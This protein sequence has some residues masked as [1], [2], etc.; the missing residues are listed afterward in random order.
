MSLSSAVLSVYDKAKDTMKTDPD[1]ALEIAN[2]ISFEDYKD[3]VSFYSK[4]KEKASKAIPIYNQDL[5]ENA[6]FNA[7]LDC[8]SQKKTSKNNLGVV[9]TTS[10]YGVLNFSVHRIGFNKKKQ[11]SQFTVKIWFSEFKINKRSLVRNKHLSLDDRKMMLKNT[12]DRTWL[13]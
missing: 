13:N 9:R 3:C 12:H 8:F 5:I 6:G 7:G 1:T 4:A 11:W 10:G 2:A